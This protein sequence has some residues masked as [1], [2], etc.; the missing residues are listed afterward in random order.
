MQRSPSD[1]WRLI[2]V[3]LLVVQASHGLLAALGTLVLGIGLGAGLLVV[4]ALGVAGAGPLLA[5]LLARGVLRGRERPLRWLVAWQCVVLAGFA[6]T[7][8]LSLLPQVDTPFGLTAL[9]LNG[10]LPVA[11]IVLARRCHQPAPV[12]AAA[13]GVPS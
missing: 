7:L 2:V 6:L 12:A 9:L 1:E 5:L 11:L 4:P 10:V 8:M 3:V 13:Q